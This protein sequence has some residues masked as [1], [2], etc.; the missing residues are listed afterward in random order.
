MASPVVKEFRCA[1]HGDFE[2]KEPKCPWGCKGTVDRVFLTPAAF[3][4][5]RT[6]R[7]DQRVEGLAAAHG[8]TD[9]SNRGG[10]A[11][12]REKPGAAQERAD[13][14]KL[15]SERYG[16]GWGKVPQ[17]GAPAALNQYHA[18]ASNVLQEV[19]P[20]LTPKPVHRIQDPQGLKL[21]PDM[22]KRA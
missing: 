3:R 16:N 12:I 7:I 4:S 10:R 15:I 17:G 5:N 19:K 20:A 11:A 6:S 13:M 9:I 8:L 14:A 22:V 2:A 18:Q 1:A 21:T